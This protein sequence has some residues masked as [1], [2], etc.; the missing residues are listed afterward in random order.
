MTRTKSYKSDVSASIHE[1]ASGLSKVGMIDKK[2]MRRFDDSCLTPVHPFTA[3]EIRRLREREAVSQSIFAHYLNVSTDSVSQ[4]E[5]G[6]KHPAGASLKL[7]ALV[8]KNG[9]S[10]IA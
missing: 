6:T 1:I 9:L 4:W 8:E 5:R 2:T 10:S 3:E 7:L